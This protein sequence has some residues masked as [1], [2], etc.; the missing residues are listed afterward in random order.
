MDKES[1]TTFYK[2][3]KSIPK[4]KGKAIGA[5][6]HLKGFCKYGDSCNRKVSHARSKAVLGAWV[7]KCCSEESG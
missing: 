4:F 7:T 1:Y 3:M 6:C 5:K 2:N